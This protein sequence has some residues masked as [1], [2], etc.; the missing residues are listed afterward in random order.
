MAIKTSADKRMSD[1]NLIIPL[2]NSSG[3]IVTWNNV[4]EIMPR[5]TSGTTASTKTFTSSGDYA[6]QSNHNTNSVGWSHDFRFDEM[7]PAPGV[8]YN[9]TYDTTVGRRGSSSSP[10]RATALNDFGTYVSLYMDLHIGDGPHPGVGTNYA[11]CAMLQNAYGAHHQYQYSGA[12]VDYTQAR[13]FLE[14]SVANQNFK[15]SGQNYGSR[16]YSQI[17]CLAQFQSFSGA[18]VRFLRFI[19]WGGGASSTSRVTVAGG[20]LVIH[21]KSGHDSGADI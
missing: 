3:D 7:P 16:L 15:I 18:N 10:S 9:Y 19:N 12:S 13:T 21:G 11:H 4:V 8:W 5:Y 2:R 20:Q 1:F 17:F 14:N 6:D